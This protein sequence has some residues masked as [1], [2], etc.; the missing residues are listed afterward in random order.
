[1]IT[2]RFQTWVEADSLDEAWEK[3]RLSLEDKRMGDKLKAK[4]GACILEDPDEDKARMKGEL[5]VREV[6]E[7]CKDL[8]NASCYEC[9]LFVHE[10]DK[11]YLI[12]FPYFW[13]EKEMAE[14]IRGYKPE[15]NAM[16]GGTTTR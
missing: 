8:E 4:F 14:I 12:K 16:E 6:K 15:H 3:L 1:M 10:I 2:V 5:T 7:F 9:P 11:C 13:N